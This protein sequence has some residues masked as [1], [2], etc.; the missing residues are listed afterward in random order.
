M[1]DG[2][3]PNAGAPVDGDWCLNRAQKAPEWT[4]PGTRSQVAL[5]SRAARGGQGTAALRTLPS[6]G[7]S[8]SPSSIHCRHGITD[9]AVTLL[10]HEQG[11]RGL[12]LTYLVN[13]N[14]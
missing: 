14:G 5:L 9:C 3:S 8:P 11:G 13:N 10:V 1:G 7:F 4:L 6:P 2:A 12:P